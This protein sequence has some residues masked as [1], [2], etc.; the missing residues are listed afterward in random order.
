MD[1]G[2]FAQLILLYKKR[3]MFTK[4]SHRHAELVSASPKTTLK[5]VRNRMMFVDM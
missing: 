3:L 5:Y 1:K 4:R 2:G